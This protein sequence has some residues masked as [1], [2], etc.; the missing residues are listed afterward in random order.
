MNLK[1]GT[2]AYLPVALP[3]AVAPRCCPDVVVVVAVAVAVVAIVVVVVV[4]VV[5]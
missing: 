1:K 4:V 2:G 5:E 3:I